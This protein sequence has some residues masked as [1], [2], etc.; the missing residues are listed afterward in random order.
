MPRIRSIR[1]AARSNASGARI[2]QT[3]A[4][5]RLEAERGAAPAHG[6]LELR[7]VMSEHVLVR[8]HDR[9]ADAQRGEHQRAGRL[10]AAHQLHDDV[11]VGRRHDVGG[12]VGQQILGD[13]GRTVTVEVAHRDRRRAPGDRPPDGAETLRSRQEGTDDLPPD[14][15]GAENADAERRPPRNDRRRCWAASRGMVQTVSHLAGRK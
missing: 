10:V 12:C 7:S 6:G 5:G 11:D 14:A 15:A 8:R 4:D 3:A 9:L 1:F 13:A 2:G